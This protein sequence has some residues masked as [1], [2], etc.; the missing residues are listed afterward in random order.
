[1]AV[2]VGLDDFSFFINLIYPFLLLNSE[3]MIFN[4]NFINICRFMNDYPTKSE[5]C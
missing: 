3:F 2:D 1:M 5:Y 4:F